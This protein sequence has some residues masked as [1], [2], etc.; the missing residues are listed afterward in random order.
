MRRLSELGRPAEV[1]LVEDDYDDVELTRASFAGAKFRV[2]LHHA[3]DGQECMS[4]LAQEGKFKDAIRPDIILLDL[5]LPVMDGRETL[6]KIKE[7]DRYRNIPVIVLTTSSN[8]KDVIEMYRQHCSAYLI[9][10]LD[11]VKF[12]DCIR[13]VTNFWFELVVLPND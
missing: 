8:G 6:V 4:F 10:P 2:N 13:Q 1:L 11:Y 9:K 3:A 5:N 12:Q 7:D